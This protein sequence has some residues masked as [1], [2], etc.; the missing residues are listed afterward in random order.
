[1]FFD[2][3]G[4]YNDLMPET[5]IPVNDNQDTSAPPESK[6]RETRIE[7]EKNVVRDVFKSFGKS[8]FFFGSSVRFYHPAQG[9]GLLRAANDIDY[10]ITL[11]NLE[12]ARDAAIKVQEILRQRGI[13]AEYSEKTK[14]G[15]CP[16]LAYSMQFGDETIP[17]EIFFV[18][19]ENK[20]G[21][22]GGRTNEELQTAAN[23]EQ[24]DRLSRFEDVKGLMITILTEEDTSKTRQRAE[25]MEKLISPL[26]ASLLLGMINKGTRS[27]AEQ[28]SRGSGT[29]P[30]QLEKNWDRLAPVIE[31]LHKVARA[32]IEGREQFQRDA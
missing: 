8:G 22:F 3:L 6:E 2:I 1:L 16:R 30:D 24:S 21:L 17:V 12:A 7:E 10:Q 4:S 9:E 25:D 18:N 26:A 29:N 27:F 13:S 23:F 28:I 32:Q 5:I 20:S 14:Y 15:D 11:E 31:K 19:E